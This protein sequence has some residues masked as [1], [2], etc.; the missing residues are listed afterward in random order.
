M[1]MGSASDW[2]SAVS[3]IIMA[4]CA[5]YAAKNAKEWITQRHFDET[6]IF[7]KIMA[8][9]DANLCRFISSSDGGNFELAL[10]LHYFHPADEQI[11]I[12]GLTLSENKKTELQNEYIKFRENKIKSWI[13]ARDYSHNPD[14]IYKIYPD[15][16]NYLKNIK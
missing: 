15:F 14:H 2:V 7:M 9:V 4:G 13:E 6:R 10:S 5:I 12:I 3:N 16:Y 1:E 8:D 11:K